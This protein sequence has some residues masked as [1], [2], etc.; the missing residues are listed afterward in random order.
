MDSAE[1]CVAGLLS[2]PSEHQPGGGL[3]ER[4]KGPD[5]KGPE[6]ELVIQNCSLASS[7]CSLMSVSRVGDFGPPATYCKRNLLELCSCYSEHILCKHGAQ[8][9]A[10]SN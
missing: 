3:S 10:L 4:N 7:Y 8:Q 9:S 1:L 2:V 6:Y 5:F